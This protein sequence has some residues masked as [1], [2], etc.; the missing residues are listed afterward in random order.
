MSSRPAEIRFDLVRG[1]WKT[2]TSYLAPRSR[3]ATGLRVD[4][5]FLFCFGDEAFD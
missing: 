3:F 2:G 4:V 1:R 5:L